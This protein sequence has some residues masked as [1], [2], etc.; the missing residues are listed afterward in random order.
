MDPKLS[1]LDLAVTGPKV[2]FGLCSL[3]APPLESAVG[4]GSPGGRSGPGSESPFPA[5]RKEL[6]VGPWGGAAPVD[7]EVSAAAVVTGTG[8]V[9]RRGLPMALVVWGGFCVVTG[10][11][12]L[13]DTG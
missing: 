4:L 2:L 13:G 11:A 3:E 1:L 8:A 10:R 6:L 9:G 7:C 5:L 12:A